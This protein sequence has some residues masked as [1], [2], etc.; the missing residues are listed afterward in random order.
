MSFMSKVL[1]SLLYP[2]VVLIQTVFNYS[3]NICGNYGIALILLSL[4]ITAI[5][6]PLYYLAERWKN[7]EKVVQKKM[8][9]DIKSINENYEG[10][11]RFYLTKAARK[12]YDY[13]W[14]YTFRTSFGLIIQISFFFAAY[15]V[16]SKY[17]GYNGVSFLFIKDLGM[18]DN[19]FSGVNVLPFVMTIINIAYSVYYTRSKSWNANKE[20]YI[21]AGIFLVLLY[22]SPSALLLYWTM[23][24]VFSFIKG[25]ILRKA[26]LSEVPVLIEGGAD[27]SLKEIMKENINIVYFFFFTLLCSLQVYW[28]VNFKYTYKYILLILLFIAFTLSILVLLRQRSKNIL[29]KILTRWGIFIPILY[30]FIL[31]RK[32]NKLLSNANIKLLTGFY[33]V[34]LIIFLITKIKNL[35]Y[36]HKI[37]I[38]KGLKTNFFLILF[39]SFWMFFYLP[40]KY[41]ISNPELTNINFDTYLYYII[42]YYIILLV[43]LSTSYL[44]L[45]STYKN[46]YNIFTVFLIFVIITYSLL[47]K[48]DVGQLDFLEFNKEK[49]LYTMSIFF[50]M[51]DA[52]ILTILM[53]L[54][55]YLF[56]KKIK[57]IMYIS[58]FIVLL[59]SG[60]LIINI[61]HTKGLYRNI[62]KKTEILNSNSY[63][64]HILSQTG[65]NVIYILADMFNG[66]YM[67][68]IL[69][70]E[71]EYRAKLDGFVWYPD[72]LS[73][74]YETLMSMPGLL[75]GEKEN[76]KTINYNYDMIEQDY[77]D[78]IGIAGTRFFNEL[79]DHKYNITISNNNDLQY[80]DMSQ[81]NV[82]KYNEYTNY[83][84]LKN[85]Y[86]DITSNSFDPQ[87][88]ILLSI[89]QSIPHYLKIILYDD[90][91]WL[92]FK[93][94]ARL[95]NQLILS[96]NNVAQLDTLSSISSVTNDNKNYFLFLHSMLPHMPYGIKKDGTMMSSAEDII[97]IPTN[98]DLAYYSAKKTIDL[99]LKYIY[100]LKQNGIYDNTIIYIFS[101]HGNP[102]IDNKIPLSEHITYNDAEG[103]I[104]RAN[105][106]MLIKGKNQSG[107]LKTD[108]L[109]ISSTDLPA[110][111]SSDIGLD[112]ISDKDP[113]L[114]TKEENLNRTR[115]FIAPDIKENKKNLY[116]VTGSIFDP[117]SWSMTP[118]K[119]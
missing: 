104:S 68:R 78:A 65:T 60:T 95:N 13:K 94:K 102:Y 71:P 83:W 74:A 16:L 110:M 79:K 109:Y 31:S 88:Y 36:K 62:N 51:L 30:L 43:I 114:M 93:N 59:L 86:I 7:K 29:L 75:G 27:K 91:D 85:N 72:C 66:N 44:L 1:T 97:N 9:K 19:L 53:L 73:A 5:T 118:P 21:M 69:D 40:I 33:V 4:F 107:E 61:Q 41:Y 89:F 35:K 25:V 42:L 2:F 58:S 99:I 76:I 38:Y 32:Y 26:G 34:Y 105:T 12:I 64:N 8:H 6:A 57:V 23:N 108:P 80:A 55:R 52:V 67:Q 45:P 39:P 100:W 3:Y 119:K 81:I 46:Y 116:Y 14:W 90:N 49:N 15:E 56:I 82:E 18:P 77:K 87:R 103:N 111:L 92:L 28:N 98:K 84:K 20:L 106:L 17:S 115:L 96:V 50:Y 47:L 112:F 48:L 113:R 117:N 37:E 54:T 22:N 63:K 101:D 70:E 11:K 24:N 10:Q